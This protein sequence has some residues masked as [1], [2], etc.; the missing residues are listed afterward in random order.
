MVQSPSWEA[1]W[2]A[3]IQEIPR[4]SRDPK[5]HYR[6]HKR[7][8]FCTVDW[9]VKD[10]FFLF[11]YLK[12]NFGFYCT[13][14]KK[15]Y[16][17]K[18]WVT[19]CSDCIDTE[20]LTWPQNNILNLG[21]PYAKQLRTARFCL[22]AQCTIVCYTNLLQWCVNLQV[23]FMLSTTLRMQVGVARSWVLTAALLEIQ[24]L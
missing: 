24:V 3:A 10:T 6:T 12:H 1:N 20:L 17:V 7:P 15:T 8:P 5:V 13:V 2:F 23:G 21:T 14:G 19:A 11:C 9:N 18:L 16:L 22:V 4:I